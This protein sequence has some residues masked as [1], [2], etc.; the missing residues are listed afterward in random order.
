MHRLKLA[1]TLLMVSLSTHLTLAQ[2]EAN[3]WYFGDYAG[4]EFGT[5]CQPV[6]LD[7]SQ[8]TLSYVSPAVLSEPRTGQLLFYTN[9]YQVWDKN[10]RV[11]PNGAFAAKYEGED[12]SP[13]VASIVPIPGQP[14]LYYLFLLSGNDSLDAG[15]ANHS[16]LNYSIIDIIWWEVLTIFCQGSACCPE[17]I[18]LKSTYSNTSTLATATAFL[19]T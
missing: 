5:D 7:N 9:S 6:A 16:R 13:Q 14:F 1:L 18:Q 2:K 4:L 15:Y 10:H 12:T 19:Y 3:T 11:M 17:L 8:M